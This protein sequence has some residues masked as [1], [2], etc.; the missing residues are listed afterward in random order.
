M[1]V[2]I[3]PGANSGWAVFA[4]E[5]RGRPDQ[6][7]AVLVRC[8]LGWDSMRSAY[9]GEGYGPGFVFDTAVIEKPR[10]YPGGRTKNPNDLIEV[11]VS[12]G[13]WAGRLSG[14]SITFVT[15][16]EWK[17]QVPKPI[18][19]RRIRAQL[20]EAE[21]EVLNAGIG[22]YPPSKA[23]NIVDAVGLGLW[24]VGRKP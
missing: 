19:H 24:T 4:N 9:G 8:G 21:G 16:S 22:D 3:D 2:A 14:V 20:T 7:P 23:H 12:A 5:Y 13:E 6:F 17:G 10:I 11:A 15:P 1:L 18:H